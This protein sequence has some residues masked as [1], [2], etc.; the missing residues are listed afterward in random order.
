MGAALALVLAA[1]VAWAAAGGLDPAYGVGGVART[2][3]AQI[4]GG[5]WDSVVQP[6]GRVVVVGDEWT[7]LRD[8]N[9]T[10]IFEWAIR[11]YEASGALDVGFGIGGRVA[12]FGTQSGSTVAFDVA[13]DSAGRLVVAGRAPFLVTTTSGGKKP[14]TTTSKIGHAVVVR[15]LAG[16]QLDTSFGTGG[17]A[18]LLVPSSTYTEA[19]AVAVLAGDRVLLGGNAIFPGAGRR[20]PAHR[21]MFLARLTAAGALDGTFGAAGLS[22]YNP[23]ANT[24]FMLPKAMAVQS[25]GRIVLG[26]RVTPPTGGNPL[27]PWVLTRHQADGSFDAA[28]GVKSQSDRTLNRL[29]VG[30]SDEILVSG[31]APYAGHTTA[32]VLERRLSDGT[33]DAAFG[34]GGVAYAA[35]YDLN[36]GGVPAVR[37]D[38]KIVVTAHLNPGPGDQEAAVVRFLPNGSLDAGFGSGGFGQIVS[39]G[40]AIT[41]NGVAFAPNGDIYMAGSGG[42]G[43]T[44]GYTDWYLA[45]YLAN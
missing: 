20:D 40:F 33:L 21:G 19:Y 4:G 25:D 39:T 29:S 45:R 24:E 17:V 13:L 9:G 3:M 7:G 18:T 12:L 27:Q 1:G 43:G 31:F 15:L 36:Q 38:G 6:D 37:A 16:G 44:G 8:A 34:A 14:T 42:T 26:S 22:V 11:R 5:V 30:P 32:V 35:L 41:A 2:R 23:T 10:Q 28:F